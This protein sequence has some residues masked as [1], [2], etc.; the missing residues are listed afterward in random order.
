MI[1]SPCNC[2]HFDFDFSG[3]IFI[4]FDGFLFFFDNLFYWLLKFSINSCGL[5]YSC[6]FRHGLLFSF[7]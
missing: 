2:F 1:L 7:H 3:F 4:N 5:G 6:L